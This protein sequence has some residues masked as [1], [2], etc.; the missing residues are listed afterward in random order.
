MAKLAA[1]EERLA[2]KEIERAAAEK[3]VHR[4]SQMDVERGQTYRDE[5]RL[6]YLREALET[7]ATQVQKLYGRTFIVEDRAPRS[8]IS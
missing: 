5:K 8:E 4:Q 1:E 2:Q 3:E 6:S 7:K